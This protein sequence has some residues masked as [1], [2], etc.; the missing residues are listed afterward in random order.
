[1]ETTD[2]SGGEQLMLGS[3]EEGDRI[4]VTAPDQFTVDAVTAKS[5]PVL[6][7]GLKFFSTEEMREEMTADACVV[8][9]GGIDDESRSAVGALLSGVT[10]RSDRPPWKLTHHVGFRLAV[11]LRLKVR[12]LWRYWLNVEQTAGTRTA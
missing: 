9:V 11:L 2:T 8:D 10:E 4:T 12:L 5:N 7:F 6:A 1:M 3:G